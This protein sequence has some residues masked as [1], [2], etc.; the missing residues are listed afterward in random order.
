MSVFIDT[1]VFYA[2]MDRKAKGHAASQ[3][4]LE[5]ILEGSHG[6]PCTSDYVVDEVY[7]LVQARTHRADLARA[8]I[9]RILEG[10]Q[11]PSFDLLRVREPTFDA[12]RDVLS[13]YEDHELSFTD[14]TIVALT[15]EHALDKVLSFDEGFDGILTRISPYEMAPAAETSD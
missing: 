9:D 15:D 3:S 14:A 5:R 1:G 6:R 2:Q 13:R 4:A 8:A 11:G 12:A 7:T 10:P